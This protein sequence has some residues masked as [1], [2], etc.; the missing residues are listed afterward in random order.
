MS[1]YFVLCGHGSFASGLRSAL[2][3]L[4]GALENCDA[5]D[6]YEG[7]R[8]EELK[9]ALQE[10]TIKAKTRPI[11]FFTDIL[12]GTPFRLCAEI[13]LKRENSE[14]I[15]G[16]NVQMLVEAAIEREEQNNLFNLARFLKL[17][18]QEGIAL[19]SEQKR[20]TREENDDGI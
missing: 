14:V 3:L 20:K 2:T 7:M 11:L 16:A 12:G 8:P 5:I 6:F 4:S 1:I 15:S 19:L 17:S 13:A 18:A 9:S 10:A